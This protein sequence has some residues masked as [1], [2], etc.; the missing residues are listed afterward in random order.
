M[1]ERKYCWQM[2]V[3]SSTADAVAQRPDEATATV[4][5]E[6]EEDDGDGDGDGDIYK[7]NR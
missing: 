1:D 2:L 3:V 5:P 7:N 6:T 4:E